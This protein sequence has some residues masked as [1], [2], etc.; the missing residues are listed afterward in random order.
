MTTAESVCSVQEKQ[1]MLNFFNSNNSD[2]FIVYG[3]SEVNLYELTEKSHEPDFIFDSPKLQNISN[4]LI[5][6]LSVRL[7]RIYF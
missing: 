5:F 6:L 2:K 4:L 3:S 1:K 7:L